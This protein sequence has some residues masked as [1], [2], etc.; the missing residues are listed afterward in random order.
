MNGMGPAPQ[1]GSC[2]QTLFP[3]S[4]PDP[5]HMVFALAS[6][7]AEVKMPGIPGA[8][9]A[10]VETSHG[11]EH[12]PMVLLNP[13]C[14]TAKPVRATALESSSILSSLDAEAAKCP[15]ESSG[16]RAPEAQYYGLLLWLVPVA[17][18]QQPD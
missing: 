16:T 8:L 15:C 14:L 12:L 2:P 5:V 6:S 11:A 3:L 18:A 9:A 13:R 17:V 4:T 1:A 7:G 10:A